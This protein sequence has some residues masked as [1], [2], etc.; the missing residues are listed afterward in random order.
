MTRF[1]SS[2]LSVLLAC[3]VAM[4]SALADDKLQVTTT[5]SGYAAIAEYL[6]GDKVEVQYI[7][8]GYQDPH[9]VRPKPS[10]ANLLTGAELFV[11]TGLDL[12]LWAPSLI[13]LSRNSEIRSG[14]KRYVAASQG[15]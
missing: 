1:F 5:L 6:G 15:V 13:D 10:L 7:V 12:E 14:Q 9:F 2:F 3:A 8:P 11:S 4:S